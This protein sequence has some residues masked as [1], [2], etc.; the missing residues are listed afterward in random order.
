M[1]RTCTENG[2]AQRVAAGFSDFLFFYNFRWYLYA[3]ARTKLPRAPVEESR[4]DSRFFS[5][6]S[7]L[8]LVI[9]PGKKNVIT[10]NAVH[11]CDIRYSR[12]IR[13]LM[14]FR[15]RKSFSLKNRHDNYCYKFLISFRKKIFKKKNL[16]RFL[17]YIATLRGSPPPIKLRV[18]RLANYIIHPLPWQMYRCAV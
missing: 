5:F 9:F 2:S 12:Y 17:I 6:R 7:L 13:R 1:R 11:I 8:T 15:K 4:G 10:E 16:T 14:S 3:R 18:T